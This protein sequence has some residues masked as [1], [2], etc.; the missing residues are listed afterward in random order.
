MILLVI[1]HVFAK[2]GGG[3]AVHAVVEG[4][5]LLGREF[6][7]RLLLSCGL[8]VPEDVAA[9]I[10]GGFFG[11]LKAPVDAGESELQVVHLPVLVWGRE[12]VGAEG[13]QQQG[14]EQVEHLKR[15]KLK[16]NQ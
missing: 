7:H 2:L 8:G 16:G 14:K 10:P 11:V 3:V 6:H 9:E 4:S 5:W 12:V 15:V 13:A 1:L